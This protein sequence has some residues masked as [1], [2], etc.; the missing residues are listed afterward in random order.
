MRIQSMWLTRRLV[1]LG[2]VLLAAPALGGQGAPV[3]VDR[4]TVPVFRFGV[5]A[6]TVNVSVCDRQGRIVRGLGPSDFRLLDSGFSRPISNVFVSDAPLSVAVLLDISGSMAVD[7]NIDRAR[8]AVT[9]IANALQPGR[10][11][12]A[13]F[14]FDT[15]LR[16]V[17]PFTDDLRW[18]QTTSLTGT[19]YGRTSLYDAVADTA[20]SSA[21]AATATGQCWW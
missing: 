9:S 16:E 2:L 13:L 10:D 20:C 12:V 21:G 14:T 18:L 7:R 4:D 17:V 6:V 3:T 15:R 11:E 8:R 1:P 5:D 19:P